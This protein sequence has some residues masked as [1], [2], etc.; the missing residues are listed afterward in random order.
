MARFQ[1]L[2]PKSV[3]IDALVIAGAVVG[4]NLLLARDDPGW[5]HLNPSPYLLIPFLIGARYGFS[6]GIISGL[7][8]SA[9][10]A[11]QQSFEAAIPIR[12]ALGDS[13]Y[14]YTSFVFF[15]GISG[16]LYAWLHRERIQ[17]EA[18]L[19]KLQ[20]SARQLDAEVR[21]LRTMKDEYDQTI[22][23]S[24]GEI[25]TLDT[26]LRRLHGY[27]LSELPGAILQLLKRQVR[28]TDAA[29]YAPPPE[30]GPMIRHALLGREDHLPESFE[31]SMSRVVSLAVER[32]SLVTLPELLQQSEPAAEETVLL[33]MP[34][35][36]EE[37]NVLAFLLITGIPF[38]S[39]THQTVDLISLIG[40]WSGEL[41]EL[42]SGAG[43]QYR[44]LAGM[45]TQRIYTRSHFCHILA[46]AYEAY[47]HHRLSSTIVIFSLKG[48]DISEQT[49]FET[50]LLKAVRNGDFPAELDTKHP[51]LAVLLPLVGSRGTDL[52]IDRC[53]KFHEQS[54]PW[55]T[56]LT[57]E[58]IPFSQA[59]NIDDLLE[60]FRKIADGQT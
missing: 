29:I 21:Y 49:R 46:L 12:L 40:N 14:L 34:L 2:R 5:L 25:S 39:F 58:Q 54:G 56:A 18:Q 15:G 59:G 8:T 48:A 31:L 52:F 4:A 6:S 30:D 33:A 55:P 10:V 53:R 57:I 13:L 23:A 7:L 37:A 20:A 41:M 16:E 17:S 24:G 44:T 47:T 28:V 36:D 38:V 50:G 9:L 11:G 32:N 51:H 22:A 19:D 26:E 42:A 43:G 60:R 35:R 3:I 1:K 45:E 27:S